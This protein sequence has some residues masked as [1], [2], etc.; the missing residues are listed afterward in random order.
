MLSLAHHLRGR[1]HPV[2]VTTTTKMGLEEADP[3]EVLLGEISDSAIEGGLSERGCVFVFSHIRG[4]RYC[5]FDPDSIEALHRRHPNCCLLVEADGARRKP[6]KGYAEYE[7]PL[8]RH[9]DRQMIVVGVDAF[10]RP[11]NGETVA[12]F[13]ELR[14]FLNVRE[15]DMLTTGLLSTL[16]NSPDMYLKNSPPETKRILCLNKA[17]LMEPEAL[18]VWIDHLR[19]VLSGYCGIAVSGKIEQEHPGEE[20][21][22]T[23]SASMANRT[24]WS[25]TGIF[26]SFC[27]IPCA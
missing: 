18:V 8:P 6:L 25:G 20:G 22:C 24:R 2:I 21:T 15:G 5:G 10:L 14:A 19:G 12:R 9:F 16:L 23:L 13:E 27:A 7:P 17:D 4:D 26:W 3:R 1:G 11:M